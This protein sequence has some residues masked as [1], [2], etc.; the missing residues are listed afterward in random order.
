MVKD[1]DPN[2]GEADGDGYDDEY[3]VGL[4]YCSYYQ[5]E[6]MELTVGDY[7]IPSFV[8]SFDKAWSEIGDAN[9]AVE[10]YSLTN[11]ANIQSKNILFLNS[12]RCYNYNY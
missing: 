10:T 6:D 7:I 9:E 5:V 8:N 4:S 3:L 2:T 11:M 1:C 12:S